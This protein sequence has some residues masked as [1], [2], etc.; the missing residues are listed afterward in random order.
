MRLNYINWLLLILFFL[1]IGN[2]IIVKL[3]GCILFEVTSNQAELIESLSIPYIAGYFVYFSTN[4][5]QKHKIDTKR[6]QLV[7]DE[8]TYK[9]NQIKIRLKWLNVENIE[10]KQRFIEIL[11]RIAYDDIVSKRRSVTA[12][13]C[14][15]QIKWYVEELREFGMPFL[16]STDRPDLIEKF[17]DATL[18]PSFLNSEMQYINKSLDELKSKKL[19]V[20]LYLFNLIDTLKN[21]KSE[22]K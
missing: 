10:D 8:V 3:F 21:L 1:A 14:L 2:L 4:L 17:K 19:D 22:L 6:I 15:N 20:G 18:R 11:K 5:Y 12:Y 13:E 9:Y 16:L 7:R